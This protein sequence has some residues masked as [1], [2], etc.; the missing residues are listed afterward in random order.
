MNL[1]DS[2][3]EGIRLHNAGQF[4]A[5]TRR[6]REILETQPGHADALHLLGV[7][8]H[9]EGRQDDAVRCITA[10]IASQPD[11]ALFHL[12]LGNVRQAQERLAEAE[13]SYRRAIGL[14]PGFFWAHNNLG[15]VLS[16]QDRADEAIASFESALQ[17]QPEAA[18]T[19][20]NLGS[21][22]RESGM[23]NHAVAAYHRAL[24]LDQRLTE[25]WFNIG[26]VLF[27]TGDL[28]GADEA[29]RAT[30]AL[31][32]TH[33][34]LEWNWSLVALARGDLATG[35]RRYEKRWSKPEMANGR[36]FDIPLWAGEPLSGKNIYL[37]GEQG[38]GDE[39]LFMSMLPDMV[40]ASG[41]CALECDVRLQSLV[42]RSF[43]SLTVV[44]KQ[45][46]SVGQATMDGFDFHCP[47]GSL[48]FHF[49]CK[50]G[51]FSAHGGYLVAAP[52]LADNWR[53]RLS[54]LDAKPKIG[55]SWRSLHPRNMPSG[56][57]YSLR[58]R[59]YMSI[60]DFSPILG[61]RDCT[62]IN[63]QYDDCVEELAWVKR[64]MGITVHSF[65]DLDPMND[66]ESVSALMSQL[67]TVVA[68]GNTVATLAGA[69]GCKT[70]HFGLES[71]SMARLGQ[72]HSLW[73][74]SFRF[75]HRRWD[76]PW[77]SATDMIAARLP[78]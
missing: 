7:I 74:P 10:A 58:S 55:I 62:F 78:L 72:K 68:P 15:N 63:L 26:N 8:A 39:I 57:Q 13:H 59:H 53:H 22:Y 60:K 33:P 32:P 76:Q 47:L 49:R 29:Y 20:S 64:E 73:F 52:N 48:P 21:V 41:N 65:A 34:S 43:P 45:P 30:Q 38:I 14:Q 56:S 24:D 54:R 2:L 42:Q 27:E 19:W 46:N 12:S 61:R 31:D 17:I 4:D 75:A 70:W 71:N 40:A 66:L 35:W 1:A 3:H 18:A 50:V 37:W 16:K 25:A 23:L 9:Q 69:L 77:S 28:D 5:A 36:R 44:G 67:D 6:Y 51:D 11:T